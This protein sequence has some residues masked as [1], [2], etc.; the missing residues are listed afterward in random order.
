MPCPHAGWSPL[1]T[2]ASIR[3]FQQG[4]ASYVVDVVEQA[5]LLPGN[6][7]D[8]KSMRKHIVF[9]NLKRD[10]AMVS[11]ST[12]SFF[13]LIL[14]SLLLLLFFLFFYFFIFMFLPS[15]GYSSHIQSRGDGKLLPPTDERRRWEV[16]CD[17][18][19]LPYGR[20][21]CVGAED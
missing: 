5:L 3:E 13:F 15:V 18:G 6:M 12:N 17:C 10:L 1:P 9:L 11:P 21:E 20:E 16:H 14:L 7:A 4:C 2:D 19:G 8:L